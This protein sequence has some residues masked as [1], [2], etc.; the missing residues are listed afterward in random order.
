MRDTGEVFSCQFNHLIIWLADGA[1][2]YVYALNR[3]SA[4]Y[5]NEGEYAPVGV[6][7]FCYARRIRYAVDD[8]SAFYQFDLAIQAPEE[9]RQG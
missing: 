8:P 9:S 2:T 5:N 3:F 7:S 4:T 1:F 6:D